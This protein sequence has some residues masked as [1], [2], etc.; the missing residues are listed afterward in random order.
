MP[1]A[2]RGLLIGPARLA[3]LD[4]MAS[5]LPLYVGLQPLDHRLQATL[6]DPR[7]ENLVQI[8]AAGHV[9]IDVGVR[10]DASSAGI[11]QALD[12]GADTPGVALG[13]DLQ[14]RDLRADAVPLGNC[15]RLVDRVHQVVGL[16]AD[17]RDVDPVDTLQLLAQRCQL[18]EV[19]ELAGDV[20]QS[21]THTPR[22]LVEG[23]G[24]R[25]A[26]QPQ[27]HGRR[28]TV[29]DAHGQDA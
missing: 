8:R 10:A 24:Q 7:W 27:L 1:T 22:A 23:F 2:R 3:R 15:N 9:W 21:A 28:R 11:N 16:V 29:L 25:R 26:H 20:H 17:V 19:G 13:G 4:V 18:V 14:V 5:P 6:L 12:R